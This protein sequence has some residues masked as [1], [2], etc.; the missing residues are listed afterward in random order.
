MQNYQSLSV[1]IMRMLYDHY[2][3]DYDWLPVVGGLEAECSNI[4]ELI[5]LR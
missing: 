4:L 5:V 1:S 2:L 3:V